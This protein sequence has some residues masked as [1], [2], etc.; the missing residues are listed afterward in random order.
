MEITMDL[1]FRYTGKPRLIRIQVDQ[2]ILS[3][4]GEDPDYPKMKILNF[5]IFM[6]M[7]MKWDEKSK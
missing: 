1:N 6:Q 5:S 3:G 4:I 2:L 7:P